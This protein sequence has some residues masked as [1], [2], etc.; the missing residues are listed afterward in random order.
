MKNYKITKNVFI[1]FLIFLNYASFSDNI[2]SEEK[3]MNLLNLADIEK[4]LKN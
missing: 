4:F 1:L 2:F 3:A